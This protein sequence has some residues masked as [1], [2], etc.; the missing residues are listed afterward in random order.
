MIATV[1]CSLEEFLGLVIPMLCDSSSFAIPSQTS[2]LQAFHQ[3]FNAALV[4]RTSDMRGPWT[5]S[6]LTDKVINERFSQAKSELKSQ[7]RGR[8]KLTF[9]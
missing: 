7:I 9:I 1:K 5:A 2:V 4:P 6:K 8:K 3:P